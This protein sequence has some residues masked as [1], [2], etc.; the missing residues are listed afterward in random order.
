MICAAFGVFWR[1]IWACFCVCFAIANGFAV[2]LGRI[3][4][5]LVTGGTGWR[6]IAGQELPVTP[7]PPHCRSGAG[8]T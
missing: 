2:V 1:H 4:G 5:T 8:V 6:T 3:F 7:V